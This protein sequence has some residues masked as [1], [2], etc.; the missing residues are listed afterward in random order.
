MRACSTDIAP[1]SFA[2]CLVLQP[3]PVGQVDPGPVRRPLGELAAVED[4]GVRVVG[5]G[6][7]AEDVPVAGLG[8][9]VADELLARRRGAARPRDGE[10]AVER[11]AGAHT[12]GAQPARAATTGSER[13][14]VA[15]GAGPHAEAR[16]VA[17]AAGRGLGVDAVAQV[18]RVATPCAVVHGETSAPLRE[19]A[20]A[21]FAF[22][23][24]SYRSTPRRFGC[25][26]ALICHRPAGV[27]PAGVVRAAVA[28]G[29]RERDRRHR[30]G[31]VGAEPRHPREAVDLARGIDR[32]VTRRRPMPGAR[33]GTQSGA[34]RAAARTSG[35]GRIAPRCDTPGCPT[36]RVAA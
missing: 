30:R 3:R 26:A 22:S 14:A 16:A 17:R 36:R 13:R 31:L 12:A 18:L 21:A 32:H 34:T 24:G 23:T 8:E 27:L 4:G 11:A 6:L 1:P 2:S 29:L 35:V 20:K 33:T 5:R 19:T 9:R 28:A 10:R 25:A 15:G 7:G